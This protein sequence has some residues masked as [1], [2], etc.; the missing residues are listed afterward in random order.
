MARTEAAPRETSTAR[1]L[2][3]SRGLLLPAALALALVAAC[4]L[5]SHGACAFAAVLARPAS[6]EQQ[7]RPADALE[8]SAS[9]NALLRGGSP[10]AQAGPNATAVTG[11]QGAPVDGG[12]GMLQGPPWS[13]CFVEAQQGGRPVLEEWLMR[14]ESS[15]VG[16][17]TAWRKSG[18]GPMS[19]RC[20]E[21]AVRA[22]D[23]VLCLECLSH[24]GAQAAARHARAGAAAVLAQV[25]AVATFVDL[26]QCLASAVAGTAA[27]CKSGQVVVP[28]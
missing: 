18:P 8:A 6:A 10:L 9:A 3:R 24:P 13:T 28:L 27:F 26:Q 7:H 5:W 12:A 19:V 15:N 22:E 16:A 2:R 11:S 21:A 23:G 25:Q 14:G 4:G 1:A 17:F 20:E